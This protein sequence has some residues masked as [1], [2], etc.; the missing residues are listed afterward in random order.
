MFVD[1]IGDLAKSIT[2][3]SYRK[4]IEKRNVNDVLQDLTSKIAEIVQY[5]H[6]LYQDVDV[7]ILEIDEMWKDYRSI[8]KDLEEAAA[9]EIDNMLFPR[10]PIDALKDTALFADQFSLYATLSRAAEVFASIPSLF[11]EISTDFKAKGGT[12]PLVG[13]DLECIRNTSNPSATGRLR[14]LRRPEARLKA[15][16]PG[17]EAKL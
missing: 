8:T 13:F 2:A 14:I 4:L 1:N 11:V 16:L 6:E 12:L 15:L 3:E 5:M 10:L 17:L 7:M 9:Q